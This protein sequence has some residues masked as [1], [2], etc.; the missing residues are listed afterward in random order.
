MT[1]TINSQLSHLEHHEMLERRIAEVEDK[2]RLLQIQAL[3]P[4]PEQSSS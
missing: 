2:V 4:P 3:M 1:M